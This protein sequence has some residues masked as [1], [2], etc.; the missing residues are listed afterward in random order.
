[1]RR[2][3]AF[4]VSAT[5]AVPVADATC[6]AAQKLTLYTKRNAPVLFKSLTGSQ[7]SSGRSKAATAVAAAA[8]A[9]AVPDELR[10]VLKQLRV[11]SARGIGRP[12]CWPVISGFQIPVFKKK[13]KYSCLFFWHPSKSHMT[14]TRLS[15]HCCTLLRVFRDKMLTRHL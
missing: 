7:Y 14:C 15:H 3:G 9:A 2:D 10:G 8:A 5:T 6:L 11:E 4:G 13:R 12:C 1:M